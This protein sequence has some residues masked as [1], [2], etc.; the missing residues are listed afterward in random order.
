MG[1]PAGG[2]PL[3]GTINLPTYPIHEFRQALEW[4]IPGTQ[5]TLWTMLQFDEVLLDPE[6][7]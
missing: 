4:T 2:A 3:R 1:R 6:Q 7:V 5:T